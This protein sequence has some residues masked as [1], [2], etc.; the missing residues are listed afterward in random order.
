MEIMSNILPNQ[1]WDRPDNPKSLRYKGARWRLIHGPYGGLEDFAV[2]ELQREVQ[3]FL[4]YVLEVIADSEPISHDDRHLILV[5]TADSNRLIRKLAE[6][7]KIELPSEPQGFVISVGDSPWGTDKRLAII[8]GSDE[9]GVLYGVQ[10]FN[11]RVIAAGLTEHHPAK[12]REA[13]DSMPDVR[14][15]EYP[16]IQNRGIWTWGYVIYDY[17]KF[18]DNMA[19][20]KLNTLTFWTDC[21]PVNCRD[22]IA[23]AHSRGIKVILG[24]EWGWDGGDDSVSLQSDALTVSRLR[25]QIKQRVLHNYRANY[26]GLGADGI[27]FQ[28]LTEFHK[29][30]AGD[31]SIAAAACELVNDIAVDLLEDQPELYIQF[32]L[33]AMSVLDDYKDLQALDP[34]MTIVW[35]DAGVLPY[36]YNPIPAHAD[37]GWSTPKM[38]GTFEK[39]VEYSKKLATFRKGSEFAMVAKGWITLRWEDEFEHH[40][41]FIIGQRSA[42][43]LQQRLA[44]RQKRWD[45]VNKL[46][47]Q[48]Y[49]L[50]ARFYR[51]ILDCSPPKVA[52]SALVEDGVFEKAIQPSVALFA[53][54]LWNPQRDDRE[55][56]QL[57]MSPYYKKCS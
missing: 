13:F 57:S 31:V 45:Y 29:E 3:D 46:W 17:R 9:F 30:K 55:I 21:P 34:R 11:A 37:S 40:G 4:P 26:R 35:E 28:T 22:I 7:K 53:E 27:Y 43:F 16:R 47:M 24:F 54:T 56:L 20:L 25:K 52:V 12:R 1:S 32:G 6:E 10:D 33:H 38:L 49:P 50:A 2:N 48:H 44:E 39:T 18:I 19:R 14:I 42:N 41:P 51:E 23:Y 36:S 15:S 8:A 5:G